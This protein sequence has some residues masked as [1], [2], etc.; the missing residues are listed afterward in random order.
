LPSTLPSTPRA[1]YGPAP[2]PALPQAGHRPGPHET[3]HTALPQALRPHATAPTGPATA[4]LKT[5]SPREC[6][7]PRSVCPYALLPALIPSSRRPFRI[8]KR[9]GEIG[10][11]TKVKPLIYPPTSFGHLV[12]SQLLFAQK[13]F[14]DK[15]FAR[16]GV[17]SPFRSPRAPA[18]KDAPTSMPGG[19]HKAPEVQSVGH[20]LGEERGPADQ[21]HDRVTRDTRVA[22]PVRRLKRGVIIYSRRLN[23]AAVCARPSKLTITAGIPGRY[24]P[25]V[26][27][28]PLRPEY[29]LGSPWALCVERKTT[30]S[31]HVCCTTRLPGRAAHTRNR[32]SLGLQEP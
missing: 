10:G 13:S 26:L 30:K 32:S 2:P 4:P 31:N 23:M 1:P 6:P 24:T 15:L 29:T 11:P 20:L 19:V 7:R 28:N 5:L 9:V 18:A 27:R 3:A 12:R 25:M 17:L 21:N 22:C 14:S 16:G 8:K